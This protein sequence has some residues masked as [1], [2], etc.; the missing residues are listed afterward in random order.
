MGPRQLPLRFAIPAR[1]WGSGPAVGRA[2]SELWS[3][4]MRTHVWGR[5]PRWMMTSRR[6]ISFAGRMGKA[7]RGGQRAHPGRAAYPPP[8]TGIPAADGGSRAA[9]G[10]FERGR[11]ARHTEPVRK[12][13]WAIGDQ[14]LDPAIDV[15]REVFTSFLNSFTCRLTR[16]PGYT[17]PVKSR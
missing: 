16:P 10:R 3:P 12:P 4:R 1:A 8:T 17:S 7:V 15:D 2:A 13:E 11:G 14:G 5:Q 6:W 9:R